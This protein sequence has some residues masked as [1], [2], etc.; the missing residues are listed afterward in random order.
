MKL[1]SHNVHTDKRTC[2]I[3]CINKIIDCWNSLVIKRRLASMNKLTLY[4]VVGSCVAL[5]QQICLK[6]IYSFIWHN[7]YHFWR[8]NFDFWTVDETTY[9]CYV[10]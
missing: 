8:L 2:N 7:L 5:L 4:L 1:Q 6:N 9:F 10:R 3:S